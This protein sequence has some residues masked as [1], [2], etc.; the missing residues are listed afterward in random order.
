MTLVPLT[1]E[2][3]LGDLLSAERY[4]VVGANSGGD[5]VLRYLQ[6]R[7][8]TVTAFADLDPDRVGPVRHGLD[9]LPLDALGRGRV[10][11][12]AIVIGSFKHRLIAERLV[13]ECGVDQGRV[14]PFVNDMFA[15]HYDPTYYR[16]HAEQFAAVRRM[17][18]DEASKAYFDRVLRFYQTLD[19]L[20]LEPNPLAYGP[21]GYRAS[22]VK[23]RA[24]A[25]IVDCGA[26]TGDTCAFYLAETQG[27]AELFALEAYAPNF[28]RLQAEIERLG[29]GGRIKALHVAAGRTTGAMLLDGDPAIADGGAHR[30][31]S[32]S[33]RSTADLML[34]ETL[35]RLF[36]VHFPTR[37]DHIKVDVEGADLDV[38]EGAASLVGRDR[39]TL[40][41]ASYHCAEHIWRIPLRACALLGPCRLYAAHDPAWVHHIHFIAVAEEH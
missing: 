25:I 29:V 36:M 18:A 28:L 15:D 12:S 5:Q 26:Y 8:K 31:A 3:S 38:L 41:L 10:Q 13:G 24:G 1:R 4:V 9:V 7:G 27:T 30:T 2:R 6:E 23:P 37:I 33:A 20:W 39:P 35:D 32:A 40:A 11:D 14:F 16:R 21:Y 19:P 22:G 17:L 34:C